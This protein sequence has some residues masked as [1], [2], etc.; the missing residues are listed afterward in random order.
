MHRIA[1]E[2][3]AAY[4]TCSKEPNKPYKEI[5]MFRPNNARMTRRNRHNSSKLPLAW[6]LIIVIDSPQSVPHNRLLRL[7]LRRIFPLHVPPRLSLAHC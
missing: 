6:A 3:N 5:P 7:T 4:M 1:E 2:P